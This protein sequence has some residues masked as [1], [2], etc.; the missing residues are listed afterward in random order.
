MGLMV[1][2]ELFVP[3]NKKYAKMLFEKGFLVGTIG[4]N[5]FRLVPPLVITKEDV[6]MFIKNLYEVLKG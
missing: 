4:T 3:E 6:D 1:G 2:I 5:V